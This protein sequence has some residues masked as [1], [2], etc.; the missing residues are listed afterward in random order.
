VSVNGYTGAISS[1]FYV[2]STRFVAE[3][4][5][6]AEVVTS[7]ILFYFLFFA[8]ILQYFGS[9]GFS[10]NKEVQLLAF[11]A[12]LNDGISSVTFFIFETF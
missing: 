1:G 3:K 5:E 10:I 11:I 8:T 6:L 2:G 9:V 7:L 12:L 4:G